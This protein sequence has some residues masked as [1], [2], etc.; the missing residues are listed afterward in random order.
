[1]T[2]FMDIDARTC[3][4]NQIQNLF[5]L[6]TRRLGA[7]RNISRCQT[8]TLQHMNHRVHIHHGVSKTSIQHL[9]KSPLYGS[10]QGSG[11]GVIN[12]HGHN[13]ALVAM[14]DRTQPG[15]LMKIP[16]RAKEAEQNVISFVD[17]NK[18]IQAF[19]WDMTQVQA[20]LLC[21]ISINFWRIM[22]KISGGL[23]AALKCKLQFLTYNF[24][25]YSYSRHYPHRVT[26]VMQTTDKQQ[27]Q[28]KLYDCSI[29]GYRTIDKIEPHKGRKLLGVCLAANG[30]C[31][32]EYMARKEQSERMAR[33]LAASLATPVDAF[34]I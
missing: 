2:A 32:D 12:W 7:D 10:G 29:S 33:Q 3:F 19:P 11:A 22:L 16:D 14:Y 31:L 24:N 6:M 28:C 27:G 25:T 23:L 21:T 34:M 26:P 17:D 1:M 4:D 15:S 8:E 13:E 30:N 18:L 5:G 9:D 20:M